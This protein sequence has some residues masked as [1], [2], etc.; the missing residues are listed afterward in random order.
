MNKSGC[1]GSVQAQAKTHRPSAQASRLSAPRRI[2]NTRTYTPEDIKSRLTPAHIEA[3]CRHW[4]PNGK[5]QGN[6]WVCCSPWRDDRTPSLGVSLT[7][8]FWKDFSTGEG[9]DVFAL[10]MR[11]FGDTFPDTVKGFAEMLGLTDGK[12]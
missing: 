12:D 2:V 11:L 6:W 8:G 1:D 3:L 4:L 7:T 10:S 9:G 5:R